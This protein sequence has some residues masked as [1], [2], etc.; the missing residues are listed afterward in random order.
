MALDPNWLYSATAQSAAAIVAIMGGF[1]VS[2][3]LALN[4]EKRT[5][6]NQLEAA[7]HR[8][9]LL[10]QQQREAYHRYQIIRVERFFD[11]VSDYLMKEKALPPLEELVRRYPD[12]HLDPEVLKHEYETLS[13]S[14]L[15]ARQ[16]LD[17]HA[18]IID[19]NQPLVF[20][21]W[22]AENKLDLS[23][24][25]VSAYDREIL[26]Q[27]YDRRRAE[28]MEIKAER[29]RNQ[30]PSI[31]GFPTDHLIYAPPDFTKYEVYKRQRQDTRLE[32][33]ED[34]LRSLQHECQFVEGEVHRLRSQLDSFAFPP[35][36]WLGFVVLTYFAG[37]GII[38]P[39]RLMPSE[40][41]EVYDTGLKNLTIG[42]FS[43]GLLAVLIY[44]ALQLRQ[45]IKK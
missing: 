36:L 23:E 30:A 37:V 12:L 41:S 34:G 44:L 27:E 43:S 19:V 40:P 10:E 13:Q 16:F 26:K 42:L 2:R 29:A 33:A 38:V 39:L 6:R 31:I 32:K 9:S 45:L 28:G 18:D 17:Q 4:S 7:R 1:I 24:L 35:N 5:L 22:L 8:L 20:E 21:D 11:D 14:S 3:I 25:D 15:A